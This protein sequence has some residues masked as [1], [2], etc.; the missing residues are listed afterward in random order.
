MNIR[1]IALIGMGAVGSVYG[2]FLYDKYENNFVVIAGGL[3]VKRLEE[4]G[5]TINGETFFPKVMVPDEK[6][7]KADLVLV[8]VKNEQLEEALHDIKN[9]VGSNTIILSLLNGVAAHNKIH[10]IYP[11]NVNLS[12][13]NIGMDVTRSDAE[14]LNTSIGKLEIG[15]S[16][17]DLIKEQAEAVKKCLIDAG[18]VSD[19]L[20][21]INVQMWKRWLT[22]V[23]V[24][25]VA[26]ILGLKYGQ[27][28]RVPA[29]I[30]LMRNVMQEAIVVTNAVQ[31]SGAINVSLTEED[32]EEAINTV[33]FYPMFAKPSMLQDIQAKRKTEVD[34]FSG[35][36][37]KLAEKLGLEM[38]I[39]KTIYITIKSIEQMYHLDKII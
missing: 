39:N 33:D 19:V 24:N 26:A 5:A 12:G 37:L 13:Y 25:Q 11:D 21:D 31:K 3:R 38:P 9:C 36:I 7:W 18:I 35:I 27:I 10:E 28:K 23:G 17:N 30:D 22:N 29:A 4:R 14:V 15:G 20:N 16:E 1:K 32:I 34:S 8:C 6:G 2:K